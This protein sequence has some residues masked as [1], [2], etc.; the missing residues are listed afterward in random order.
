MSDKEQNIFS[1]VIISNLDIAIVLIVSTYLLKLSKHSTKKKLILVY[2]ILKKY[3]NDNAQHPK[4]L[5]KCV[6]KERNQTFRNQSGSAEIWGKIHF[7]LGILCYRSTI[8]ICH[9]NIQN[10]WKP[11]AFSKP[12]L[13]GKRMQINYIVNSYTF[14]CTSTSA[15]GSSAHQAP[16]GCGGGG[17]R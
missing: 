6:N 3:R 5:N 13:I 9:S 14:E 11:K 7:C 8:F 17:V 16:R 1:K 15:F 12:T 10:F 2:F 4:V